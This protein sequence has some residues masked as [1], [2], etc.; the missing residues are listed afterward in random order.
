MFIEV[1]P[2]GEPLT[3]CAEPGSRR[4]PRWR[5]RSVEQSIVEKASSAGGSQ[6]IPKEIPLR[7]VKV[8]ISGGLL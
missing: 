2:D 1:A 7:G 5:S 4:D 3:A 8:H 6:R